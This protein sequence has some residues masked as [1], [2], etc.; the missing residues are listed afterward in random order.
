MRDRVKIGNRDIGRDQPVY[1]IAEL[2]ANHN[3]K[4][5]QAAELVSPHEA[6][7]IDYRSQIW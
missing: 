3:Q 1:L 6:A 7:A 5:E 4:F 2:S